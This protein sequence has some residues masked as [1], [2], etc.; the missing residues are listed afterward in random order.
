MNILSKYKIKFNS[1]ETIEPE[2]IFFD[3]SNITVDSMGQVEVPIKQANI[4]IFFII[5]SILLVVFGGKVLY[6][7]IFRYD[8]F[9]QIAKSNKMR[10]ISIEAPRGIIFDRSG[11]QLVFNGSSFDLIVI[12]AFFP[13]NSPERTVLTDKL[14]KIIGETNDKISGLIKKRGNYFLGEVVIKENIDYDSALLFESQ[15]NDINGVY[16]KQKNFRKYVDGEYFS[17]ILGYVGK[18]SPDEILK[19]NKYSIN[20]FIGKDGIESYYEGELRGVAGEQKIEANQKNS[21][22]KPVVVKEPLAGKNLVLTIDY[23]LQKKLYDVM[24]R[25][26]KSLNLRK[27]AAIIVHPATGETLALVSF[28][29]FDNNTFSA[30][31][32]GG[33]SFANP[34]DVFNDPAK[35][36][37][38]RAVSGI[39]P[40]GSTVKPFLAAGILE[41]GLISPYKKIF[42][43]GAITIA[44]QYNPDVF[45][46]FHDWKEHGSINI[47][48]AIAQSSNVYFYTL[49]G[50]YGNIKGLGI[51]RIKYYLNKFHFGLKTGID[52]PGEAIGIIPDPQWKNEVKN[53]DWYIGD[54][55]NTSI[56]QGDMM[57]TPIQLV[58]AA[59]Y[60][61]TGKW[62]TP[63]LVKKIIDN[64]QYKTIK[65]N[66]FDDNISD[67]NID[68]ARE[69]MRQA[70]V[71]GSAQALS[72]ISR[73]VAGKTGTAQ[74][75]SDGKYHAWFIGFAPF[76][77]PN[78]AIVVLIEGGGEGSSVAVPVAKEVL[79][80]YFGNYK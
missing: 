41:E 3:P 21:E 23:N 52:L 14:S 7:Q 54:T 36:L 29:S 43:A 51:D 20:D 35:P 53:E 42:A 59:S 15:I 63:Y 16:L 25:K 10:S 46:T 2:E 44:D 57:V 80:W 61:A 6:M 65:A 62:H 75:G 30:F 56:G 78:L 17:H 38:N 68:I 45:Y 73:Q 66:E 28:P 48:D 19:D 64:E 67:K 8:Y 4:I 9:S 1:K 79:E 47:I 69:G 33:S 32:A 55:Y 22:N 74:F 39:Y 58:S 13:V 24:L 34:Q 27:G 77:N 76:D 26:L 12:P 5:T 60:I 71:R 31:N 40:P 70:V 49:G 50:G 72:G 18:I 11:R 37:F